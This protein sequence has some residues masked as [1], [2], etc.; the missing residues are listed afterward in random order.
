MICDLCGQDR[1]SHKMRHLAYF[2]LRW[3][4]VVFRRVC[5]QCRQGRPGA[6]ARRGIA[7]TCYLVLLGLVA[8]AGYGMVHL[9]LWIARRASTS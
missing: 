2:R 4:P 3:P 1:P 7:L 8:A 6:I 5:H 9:A